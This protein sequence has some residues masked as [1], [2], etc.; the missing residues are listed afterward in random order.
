MRI[1]AV[2][3]LS[4]FSFNSLSCEVVPFARLL[5]NPKIFSGKC[6]ETVGVISVEFEGLRIYSDRESYE[7]GVYENSIRHTYFP[8]IGAE[9]NTEETF[10]MF[11]KH[12]EGKLVRYKGVFNRD[13]GYNRLP[14]PSGVFSEHQDIIILR[15][16]K[17]NLKAKKA[18]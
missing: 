10:K 13:E 18:E 12:F 2:L 9:L 6:V 1:F 3:A 8:D 11:T 14:S 4:I 15:E 16:F 5:A 7:F 17:R